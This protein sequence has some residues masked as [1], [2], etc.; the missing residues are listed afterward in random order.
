[1]FLALSV[2]GTAIAAVASCD[3]GKRDEQKTLGPAVLI[4][5][6]NV[7]DGRPLPADGAI[8]I[9]FDR[10]LLPATVNGK[11]IVIV[12]GAN[13]QLAPELAPIILYDPITR[14]V[15]L[16]PPQQ[17]WLTEGQPYKL[18]LGIPAGDADTGGVRAIDRATL[19]AD[20]KREFAFFVGLKQNAPMEPSVSF[21]RDVLPIFT[22]KCSR[23]TCH[24]GAETAA[25]SLLLD[26]SAGVGATA[27][28]R[29][30]QGSNRGPRAGQVTTA[31]RKFGIDMPI[32]DPGN[33]GNSWLMYKI[34]L[35]RLPVAPPTPSR[36]ACTNGLLEPEVDFV[37]APLAPNAQHSA[38]EIERSILA[39]YILG[40]EMPF[41]V[42]GSNAYED[43]PLTFDE[44]E[45]VRLWI[46]TL[47]KGSSVPECGGCGIVPDTDAGASEAGTVD[48][49]GTDAADAGIADAADQ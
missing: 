26:T 18:I 14:T 6:V 21:C 47:P 42:S 31:D 27:L 2:L 19:F 37:F 49:G 17:P 16:A 25:A 46:Q 35:A 48:S 3:A 1:M 9:A 10:Y 43:L 40:R 33:P 41:P 22:A 30:A 13:Q 38:D 39:D 7:G 29:V 45:R 11:S 20:Q 24:G 15:T 4:I 34:D 12:D 28:N 23:P 44:R 8:Q 36:Y 5:G 32:V